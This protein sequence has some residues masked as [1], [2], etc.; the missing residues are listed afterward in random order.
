M[1]VVERL[2]SLISEQLGLEVK[3]FPTENKSFGDYFTPIAFEL[4]KKL[5]RPPE[6]IAQSLSKKLTLPYFVKKIEVV[7]GYLN[8]WLTEKFLYE[9]LEKIVKEGKN[10]G[11]ENKGKGKKVLLEF[12]SANPTGPLVV[13]NGRAGVVGDTLA[14]I[15]KFR[16]YKVETEY[17]VDDCGV[18]IELL[19]DSIK[20]IKEAMEGKEVEFP[21]EGY[22]GEYIKEIAK[23][24]K[25]RKIA[26]IKR[27]A[28]NFIVE[29]QKKSLNQFGIKFDNWYYES[30]IRES[31]YPQKV[32]EKLKSQNFLYSKE[33][34]VWVKTEY[35][36]KVLVKKG[37]DFTYRFSDIAYH[38]EKYERGYDLLI[39]LFG[40]DQSHIPELKFILSL[41]G[42]TEEVLKIITIEWTTFFRG[43]EKVSMSKRKG[44]FITLEDL[45]KEV[46]V[47]VSRF[48]F[49]MRRNE[50]HLEFDIE[51][52][53]KESKDNPVYYVQYAIAR[54][55]SIITKVKEKNF[56][57]PPA[58]SSL[59]IER[60][61][62]SLL[63]KLIHFPEILSQ[64]EEKFSPHFLPFYLI[65]LATLFH[66]FYEKH[67][68]II[69]NNLPL[70]SS[71]LLLIKAVRQVFVNGLSLMGISIPERM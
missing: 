27:Y 29:M 36:E 61:E 5:K 43:G 13:A 63:R 45:I 67:R 3:F 68:V 22:K 8:F 66:N 71:R 58:N 7:K 47:D 24:V 6:K 2:S 37:G 46:G 53:K 44:E 38:L 1:N 62:L 31:I 40:P 4:S 19:E 64:I 60:E 52:A 50:A 12:I 39:D 34:A 35:G 20:K 59:L 30:K 32:I 11:K 42:I 21:E 41:F 54:I 23:E 51:L 26:D 65:E 28:I 16:G 17:Y 15:L 69:E 9:Y 70:T 49:L 25:K 18:Q 55:N 33:G 14:R 57:L 10:F 56:S 48:F